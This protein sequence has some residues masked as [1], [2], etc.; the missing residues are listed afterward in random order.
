GRST[1]AKSSI[2][3]R[4][5]RHRE[6][7]S[8]KISCF[9]HYTLVNMAKAKSS[10]VSGMMRRLPCLIRRTTARF[11]SAR[12]NGWPIGRSQ[13]PMGIENLKFWNWMIIGGIV[14]SLVGYASTMVGPEHDPISRFPLSPKQFV[15]MLDKSENGK[16]LIR[17]VR[18]EPPSE[19]QNFVRGEVLFD[20]RY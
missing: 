7:R 20:D 13:I 16:P 18:I 1:S 12:S 9:S 14:G 19:G 6:H 4:L 10:P 8:K 3:R 15:S 2:G 17:D 11:T 5:S